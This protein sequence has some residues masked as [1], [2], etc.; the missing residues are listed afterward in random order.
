MGDYRL[1]DKN[2][3][4][5]FEGLKYIDTPGL[6]ASKEDDATTLPIVSSSD[7]N[8]FVHSLERGELQKDEMDY[9]KILIDDLKSPE[10]FFAKTLF[11]I[12]HVEGKSE[13]E[14]QRGIN[15]IKE[16][17]KSEFGYTPLL[18]IVK[19]RSYLKGIAE[20]KLLL[21]KQS[22]IDE[23]REK[24]KSMANPKTTEK[25]RQIRLKILIDDKIRELQWKLLGNGMKRLNITL[26]RAE[27]QEKV[28]E[29][30]QTIRDMSARFK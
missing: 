2:Q 4:K 20:N 28:W 17:I 19:T 21:A 14:I 30:N 24:I 29:I 11:I 22:G 16:Q 3:V 10:L 9:L 6:N 15:K 23:L 18:A 1:T 26:E 25:N 27:I 13:S 7:I 8:L 12:N 5:E